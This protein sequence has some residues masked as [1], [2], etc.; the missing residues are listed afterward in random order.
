MYKGKLK[1]VGLLL[2][3]VALSCKNHV[4]QVHNIEDYLSWINDVENGLVKT[5][6]V[7]GLKITLK[8]L[9][10]D[11]LAYKD[12]NSGSEYTPEA[13]DSLVNYY[14]KSIT[15]MMN[16]KPDDRE[17][18]GT[19]IMYREIKNY[20]EYAERTLAMN[21]DMENYVS[22]KTGHQEYKPVLSAMENI[23]GLTTSRNI[24][25]VFAPTE[26]EQKDDFY[27]SQELDFVY[28]DELF[29]LGI[30]HFVFSRN[31]IKKTL[32]LNF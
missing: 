8:Y 16:I 29:D 12:R 26:E 9:S 18:T 17:K 1:Y 13:I 19:D 15:F 28:E 20:K 3:V 2:L 27:Q 24:L 23:Y 21:F 30:N 11:Y 25:F 6:Y 10:P 14:S 31:D 32:Q 22:L 7:N 4:V 5:K